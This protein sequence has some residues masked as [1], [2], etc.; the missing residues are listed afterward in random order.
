MAINTSDRTSDAAAGVHT[1]ARCCL[2]QGPMAP[3]LEVSRDWRRP[4]RADGAPYRVR[5]CQ[6]CRF[7]RVDP[8]P[9]PAE[10][11]AAYDVD[12]YYTHQTV[13]RTGKPDT[14]A[15][16]LDRV[17]LALAWRADHGVMLTVDELLRW[18]APG[19]RVCDLGCGNARLL[20]EGKARGLSV[21]GV[22]PDPAARQTA[23]SRGVPV[24]EG[25]AED[26]PASL[27]RDSFD[28]VVLSHSLEHCLDPVV[29]LRHAAG[30]LRPGGVAL[31]EVPNN[32]AAGLRE[33]GAAW[34][35]MDVPRHL[36]FFTAPSLRRLCERVGLT[37]Q[38]V[39]FA[40]YCRQFRRDWIDQQA[41][42]A[43]TLDAPA[44]HSG[45][46]LL[47][48]TALGPAELKYDSVRVVARRAAA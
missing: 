17:R 13:S 2:C 18:V 22:E 20:A 47:L 42:I 6:V 27:P 43:A 1:D 35:W 31:V 8:R 5:W 32:E 9:T 44:R 30:L 48:R 37:P 25:T 11:A 46:R 19:G 21:V 26:L 24:L 14:T 40:G 10:L 23:R 16:L 3:W 41:W 12:D 38:Q 15:S 34:P 29:A 33:A 39:Q 45:L 4:D 28:A 7:G 36:S